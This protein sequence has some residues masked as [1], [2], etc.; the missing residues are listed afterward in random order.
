VLRDHGVESDLFIT[1]NDGT[2]MAVEYARKYPV[3]T[4]ASGPTNSL[5]GA[6]FLS[7]LS[8]ALV[9]D[10]GGTTTDVGILLKGF[11]RESTSAMEIGGV[12]TNFRMPDLI[13]IGLGGGSLIRTDNGS[14]TVGPDSVGYKITSEALIFGGKTLTATDA[15]VAA[16]LADLG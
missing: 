14:C 3:F 10:V 13:S 7:G 12:R 16:G 6:A 11:P 2:L 15:A 9:V 8:D 1:Q 4:I 5:R